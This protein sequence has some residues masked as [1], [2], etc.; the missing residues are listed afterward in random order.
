MG[1]SGAGS[2]MEM[3]G[4]SIVEWVALEAEAPLDDSVSC[5]G[6]TEMTAVECTASCSM[7]FVCRVAGAETKE[8]VSV[9]SAEDAK[10][11]SEVVALSAG[12]ARVR[13]LSR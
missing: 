9:R 4:T 5:S 13:S 1:V 12:E 3:R 6:V 2:V 10:G 8:V 7:A 11:L